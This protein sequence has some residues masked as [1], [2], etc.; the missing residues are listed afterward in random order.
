MG[1]YDARAVGNLILDEAG[2]LGFR[3]TN[4]SLQKLI[5]FSHGM[6]LIEKAQ[7]LVKGHF[8]AWQY[9]PVHPGAY[10]A[11][12][13]AGNRAI[14]FRAQKL[15]PVTRKL[16]EFESITDPGC[17]ATIVRVVSAYGGL[18]S[19]RLVE[20]SHAANAPWAYVVNESKTRPMIGLRITD[21]IIRERFRFHKIALGTVPR[22]GDPDEDAPFASY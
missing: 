12:K 15:N 22:S 2:R 16:A 4:L 3:I 19:G 9:G 7:P 18:T 6:F 5:Y 8:E 13:Q 20:L 10:D 11:Y 1:Q 17:L 14:D 21:Q